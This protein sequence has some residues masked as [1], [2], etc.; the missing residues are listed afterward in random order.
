MQ[1]AGTEARGK[2]LHERWW[3]WW[4]GAMVLEQLVNGTPLQP[5][6][7]TFVSIHPNFFVSLLDACV[8][9]VMFCRRMRR[10]LRAVSDTLA[11]ACRIAQ[12]G[13]WRTLSADGT[14]R[15]QTP[16]LTTIIGVDGAKSQLVFIIMRV[17]FVL[18]DES[19]EQQ[20]ADI[21]E[22]II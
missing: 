12:A 15:P 16:L 17:G 3:P 1:L 18:T 21:L 13:A 2:G 4:V 10:E 7:R 20:V 8:Q 14:A 11:A 19:S 9:S 5:S 6:L 22:K